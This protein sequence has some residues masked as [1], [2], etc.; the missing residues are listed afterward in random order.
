MAHP[1][2]LV[3]KLTALAKKENE[4]IIFPHCFLHRENLVAKTIG[5]ELKKVMDQVV[6]MVNY[7]KRRPLQSRLLAKISQE[8]GEK[9]KNVLLHTE[10]RWLSR[11][12]VL[13]RVYKLREMMLQLFRENMHNEFCDLIQ[14]KIWCT[15]LAY[16]ADIFEHL[17]KINTNR[18]MLGKRE[19]VLTSVNKIC[20]IRDKITIWIR[21][22]KESNFESFSKTAECELK[23]ISAC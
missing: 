5:N 15:K 4:K 6:Q 19:N 20:A 7:V 18:P 12:R 14:N 10:V 3:Q 13:C 22:V 11:G 9:F 17:N 23:M 16:L 21:K 8:M 1:Q 2:W